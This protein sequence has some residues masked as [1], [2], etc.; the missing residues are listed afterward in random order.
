MMFA[1]SILAQLPV[2][3]NM[4]PIFSTGQVLMQSGEPVPKETEL[5]LVCNGSIQF[6]GHPRP[7]G[8]FG[9]D[10]PNGRTLRQCEL[11]AFL[12]GHISS[13]I[14]LMGRT[15]G[16]RPDIGTIIMRIPDENPETS[17]LTATTALAPPEAAE[18]FEQALVRIQ[19]EDWEDAK[20]HL[21]RAV[22]IFPRHAEAWYQ[23]GRVY[24]REASVGK[25]DE[26]YHS[27]LEADSQFVLPALRLA[28]MGLDRG[29]FDTVLEQSNSV[30]RINP[31]NYPT[32]YYFS[33]VAHLQLGHFEE[34][35]AAAQRALELDPENQNPRSHYLMGFVLA[36]TGRL[37]Q[38][39]ASFRTYL[40]LSPSANDA[41]QV[42]RALQQIE[43]DLSGGRN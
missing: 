37:E 34:A 40:E 20:Q 28:S 22:E 23:L 4:G 35:E 10:L 36:Q 2:P 21:E 39:A 41:G 19:D 13:R 29:D 27:A 12:L 3:E 17:S 5:Q 11:R 24:E 9:L 7:D 8:T 6:M 31:Y 33:G 18:E 38:A 14:V 30:L 25:A 42:R 15:Y 43:Q 1:P 26:A 32:A 16:D